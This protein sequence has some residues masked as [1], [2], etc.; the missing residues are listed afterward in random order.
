MCTLI[1]SPTTN[2]RVRKITAPPKML[3]TTSLAAK[4]SAMPVAST[5]H[6]KMLLVQFIICQPP[7][8][9]YVQYKSDYYGILLEYLRYHQL[10]AMIELQIPRYLQCMWPL[11]STRLRILACQVLELEAAQ[12]ENSIS[13]YC[14]VHNHHWSPKN[15]F[16]VILQACSWRVCS[17]FKWKA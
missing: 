12:K 16:C 1:L 4:P 8:H 10:L 13:M 11:E 15:L 17:I 6:C 9:G 5:K 14:T 2:G 3:L 7:R